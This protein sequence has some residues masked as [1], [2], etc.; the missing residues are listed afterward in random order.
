MVSIDWPTAAA[1]PTLACA[2]HLSRRINFKARSKSKSIPGAYEMSCAFLKVTPMWSRHSKL[3]ITKSQDRYWPASCT[4][5]RSL[6]GAAEGVSRCI[7]QNKAEFNDVGYVGVL[8]LS[9][10]LCPPL[11]K[12]P[13]LAC[14]SISTDAAGDDSRIKRALPGGIVYMNAMVQTVEVAAHSWGVCLVMQF[15]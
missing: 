12:Y 4:D 2:K 14:T 9:V 11:G 15:T 8:A 7:E 1:L 3:G 13:S 5:L 6:P 10:S